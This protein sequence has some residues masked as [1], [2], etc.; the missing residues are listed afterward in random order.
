VA[1]RA[2]LALDLLP[3]L[4][5]A[6]KERQREHGGTA[7][8][9]TSSDSGPSE[10]GRADQKAAELVGVGRT[11][12]TAMGRSRPEVYQ[13]VHLT[14]SRVGPGRVTRRR[15]RRTNPPH[16][17]ATARTEMCGPSRL[18]SAPSRARDASDA[19]APA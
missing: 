15:G 10:S 18:A 17:A 1:Q 8:G 14:A 4:E 7:P 9:I 3:H 19:T 13:L 12:V 5:A 2:V 6:A 11:T 16:A